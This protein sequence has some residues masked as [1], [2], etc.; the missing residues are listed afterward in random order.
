MLEK[1]ASNPTKPRSIKPVDAASL[2]LIDRKGRVPRVLMGRRHGGHVFMPGY[3]VFPGGRV[4]PADRA[5]RAY[6]ALASHTERKLLSGIA[7]ATSSRA[8]ALALCAV[9]ETAEETGLLVGETGLGVPPAAPL[10]WAMFAEQAVF[11]ILEGLHFVARAITPPG[12]PRRFDTRFFAADAK[13]VGARV[14][15]VTGPD[16]ELV[17]ARWLTLEESAHENLADITRMILA[18]VIGRLDRGL[19]NDLPVP[20]FASRHGKWGREEI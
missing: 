19:E 11:P 4:E 8:R 3:M 2:V 10:S 15:D 13:L 7:R 12:H 20:F 14:A 9:R 5:M 16:A 6:G 1:N 17:E 18:E